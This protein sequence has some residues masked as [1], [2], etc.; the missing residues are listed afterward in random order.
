MSHGP[1]LAETR[2]LVDAVAL[3]KPRSN[4]PHLR[5]RASIGADVVWTIDLLSTLQG[6]ARATRA[7]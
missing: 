7:G 2:F 1:A 3:E 5:R 4:T 6:R